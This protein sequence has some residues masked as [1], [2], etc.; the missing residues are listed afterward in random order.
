MTENRN[1]LPI[2]KK[3]VQLDPRAYKKLHE[4]TEHC[5]RPF[6]MS[7]FLVSIPES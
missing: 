6:Q 7:Y 4:Q 3:I 2:R 1:K 5:P